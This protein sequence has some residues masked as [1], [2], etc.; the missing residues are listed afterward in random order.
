VERCRQSGRAPPGRRRPGSGPAP[1][2]YG[3]AEDWPWQTAARG[4]RCL[5]LAPAT[6]ARPRQDGKTARRRQ[7]GCEG[8]SERRGVRE[9]G[10][11]AEVSESGLAPSLPVSTWPQQTCQDAPNHQRTPKRSHHP[12]GGFDSPDGPPHTARSEV[13][14]ACHPP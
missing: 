7:A 4:L 8:E 9:G 13:T 12:T 3:H 14:L 5:R 11:R 2:W 1:M 6:H 10:A